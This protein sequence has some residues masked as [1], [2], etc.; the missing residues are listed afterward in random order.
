MIKCKIY[1]WTKKEK[2][3]VFAEALFFNIAY[4]VAMLV[5]FK[6]GLSIDDFLMSNTIYGV[7]GNNYNFRA[8][9]MNFIYGRLVVFLL[10]LLPNI[11]WYT[12]MYYILLFVA[13]TLFAYIV[14]K[15]DDSYVGKIVVN[16]VLLFFSYEGYVT[17]QFTKVAGIL[18]AIAFLVMLT[19]HAG[20]LEKIIAVILLMF[21][22][23]IRYDCAKMAVG[24]WSLVFIFKVV[25]DKVNGTEHC[26]LKNKRASIW[27]IIGICIFLFIPKISY[28]G[29]SEDEKD[30]W[31]HYYWKNNTVRSLV[32]DYGVPDYEEYQ[33]IYDT[34]DISKN[35]LYIWRSW[36]WDR[37]V[38]TL[39]KG[40]ILQALANGNEELLNTLLFEYQSEESGEWHDQ[41]EE[42]KDEKSGGLISVIENGGK[43]II[44]LIQKVF[45]INSIIGFFKKFPKAYLTIDVFVVY[46]GMVLISF[47][48]G[49][50]EKRWIIWAAVLSSGIYMLLNYYLYIN[51]RYLQ[52][53]VDIGIAMAVIGI[54]LYF[55]LENQKS[56]LCHSGKV[57]MT[58]FCLLL[59]VLSGRYMYYGDDLSE[60][61]EDYI[62]N[63]NLF[64]EETGK[65]VDNSYFLAAQRSNGI[66]YNL[67]FYEAFDVPRVG[68]LQNVKRMGS[69]QLYLD[70]PKE[71]SI[72]WIMD[73]NAYLVLTDENGDD[74]AWQTYVSEHCGKDVEMPL[75]KHYF[76]KKL[77][78]VRSKSL[79]DTIHLPLMETGEQ[80]I[81][82]DLETTVVGDRLQIS[83]SAFLQ[84][85]SGFRQNTYI[86]IV[87]KESGESVF[88]D[89][90]AFCNSEKKYG[91]EGYFSNIT[92]DIELPEFYS[93]D[94][95]IELVI[96]QD[97]KYYFEHIQT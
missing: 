1:E 4:M 64:F 36:N 44:R 24:A 78:R 16:L 41:I 6:P 38:V 3:Y 68:A 59:L 40:E 80:D 37:Y 76:G 87:D 49:A 67:K 50:T 9:Y 65:D 60:I 69:G 35:D 39:K 30:F 96:E 62:E 42:V 45:N 81:I 75:V 23:M 54:F 61:N 11:P 82:S 27:M 55:V 63:N 29:L 33:E 93:K 12:I 66:T 72:F 86:R 97:G 58:G 94:D 28:V 25:L 71:D 70:E 18:G 22:S 20:W 7:N 88:Y 95:S 17:I 8:T 10:R 21:S 13:F 31:T 92:C 48:S 83:G 56:L 89:T 84:G 34:L 77:Y 46:M 53:R 5:L 2:G 73:K 43:K 15:W 47:F 52:H 19:W 51:L 32:Q 74:M 79:E 26:L 14:L 90:L 57:Q 85:E 91:E